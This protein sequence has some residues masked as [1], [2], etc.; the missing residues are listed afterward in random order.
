MFVLIRADYSSCEK[1]LLVKPKRAQV[2]MFYDLLTEGQQNA[3]PGVF[4]ERS[5][6]GACDVKVGVKWAANK[7]YYNKH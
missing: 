6:H 5:L 4:D 3:Q 7:W 1:G 2:A